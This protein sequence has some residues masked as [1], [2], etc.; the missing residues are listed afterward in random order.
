M[1]ILR[2]KDAIALKEPLRPTR[3]E[4]RPS[5]T[6]THPGVSISLAAMCFDQHGRTMDG[7][8]LRWT[9]SGG[10]ID[11]HG[12]FVAEK[13]GDYRVQAADGSLTGTAEVRVKDGVIIGP[14]PDPEPLPRGFS[15]KGT[16]PPQKWM[17]FYTKVLSRFA[18][19]PS[20]GVPPP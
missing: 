17:D 5:L 1:V 8:E 9:A 10:T 3:I 18:S 2:A 14:D 4:I 13:S 19:C 15:W 6:T 11:D 16:V 12:R 20:A 7:G